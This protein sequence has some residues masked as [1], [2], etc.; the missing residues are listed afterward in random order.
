MLES[1]TLHTISTSISRCSDDA[2][3]LGSAPFLSPGIFSKLLIPVLKFACV[4]LCVNYTYIVLFSLAFY[5]ENY[6]A[7]R[8]VEKLF[9]EYLSLNPDILYIPHSCFIFLSPFGLWW[10]IW[11]EV[12]NIMTCH[13]NILVCI[14]YEKNIIQNNHNIT[15][16]SKKKF[17]WNQ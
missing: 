1:T 2:I 16:L 17:T 7:Y 9:D 15:I 8:K 12:I 3:F 14:S 10:T 4:Y 5:V 6:Q 11:K 13:S